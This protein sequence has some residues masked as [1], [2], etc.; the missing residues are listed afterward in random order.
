MSGGASEPFDAAAATTGATVLS[1]SV[2]K[3]ASLT[4]PQLCALVQS[5]VAARFLGPDGMG[6]QSFIAFCEI[7]VV[8]LLSTEISQKAMKLWIPIPSGPRNRA[9][10][11]DCTSA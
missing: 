8:S 10:T 7:S 9:A 1:G 3:G 5:I 4:L 11:I 6:I 2:W